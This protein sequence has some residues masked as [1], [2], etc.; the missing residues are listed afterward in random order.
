MTLPRNDFRVFIIKEGGG[1]SDTT[2]VGLE[3]ITRFN[4]GAFFF[5]FFLID[6]T[7]N[8]SKPN[9]HFFYGRIRTRNLN[10]PTPSFRRQTFAA[11]TYFF[12]FPRY[13]LYANLLFSSFIC[14]IFQSYILGE[15]IIQ[16]IPVRGREGYSIYPTTNYLLIYYLIL[17]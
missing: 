8:R 3:L 17:S 11:R 6:I 7:I 1:G 5:L 10:S 16:V 15:S 9:M 2:V 12:F 13:Q 14:L 4:A